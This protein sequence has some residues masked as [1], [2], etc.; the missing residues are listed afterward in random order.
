MNHVT[1]PIKET[2]ESKIE[3]YSRIASDHGVSMRTIIR[4]KDKG[5]DISD[6][7]SLAQYAEYSTSLI[8]AK[9]IAE[10]IRGD[11]DPESDETKAIHRRAEVTQALERIE[12]KMESKELRLRA[13]ALDEFA[14]TGVRKPYA[15][16]IKS[17]SNDLYLIK[18]KRNGMYKIGVSVDPLRREK[19]LQSQEPDIKIVKIWDDKA[20]MERWW[21]D[22]FGE[23]RVRGEWFRLNPSQ[24]RFM[25]HKM[26][27]L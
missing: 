18:N 1:Q 3:K 23:H 17:R 8:S 9:K 25:I 14:K 12:A 20:A 21:H 16:S 26:N 5:C 11:R 13:A 27:E 10:R 2:I 6:P 15:Q 7:L 22:Y 24:I 19:T 4:W